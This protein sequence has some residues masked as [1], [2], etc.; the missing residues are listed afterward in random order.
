[1]NPVDL[2][3]GS[4]LFDPEWYADQ[5]G[6]SREPRRAARHYL[7]RG[8]KRGFTPHPLFD[9]RYFGRRIPTSTQSDPL[10]AFLTDPSLRSTP[11][12]PLFDS[13]AYLE[14][15]PDAAG[16]PW[17]PL[18]HYLEVGAAAGSRPNDWYQPHPEQEPGGIADWIRA[19]GREWSSRRRA[20]LPT[21]TTNYDVEAA[22]TVK[23]QFGEASPLAGHPGR[24]LV[25]V[26]VTSG[27]EYPTLTSTLRSVLEQTVPDVEILVADTGG[28]PN[29]S[30]AL[31]DSQT[32]GKVRVLGTNT[33]EVAALNRALSEGAGDYIAWVSPGERWEPDRLRLL[34]SACRAGGFDGVHDILRREDADGTNHFAGGAVTSAHLAVHVRGFLSQL[35]VERRVIGSVAPL[36]TTLPNGWE[37][38]FAYRA[39][40]TLR[41]GHVPV[42]G[43]HRDRPAHEQ[44]LRPP[45]AQRP[46]ADHRYV[47]TWNDVVVNR[48]AIDWASLEAAERDHSTVSVIIPTHRDWRRTLTA[49]R[50]V[51]ISDRPPGTHVEVIVYD[52]GSSLA[53]S[54]VLDSAAKRFSGVTVVHSPI[55][56]GFALGNNFALS[57]TRGEVVVFLN[58]DTSVARDWLGPLLEALREPEVLA[59]Q[60]LLVYPT[61]SVQSAG[62]AFPTC[63][64]IPHPYL[65]GFPVKDAAHVGSLSFGALTGAAL[66][67]RFDDVVK[68][69]GFDPLFRNGMED[70]DFCLRLGQHRD[71]RLVVAPS[72]AV[73]HHESRTPGR[74]A[75]SVANRRLYLDRWADKAPKDDEQL[76]ESAGFQVVGHEIRNQVADDRRLCVPEPVLTRRP[77]LDISELPPRL[78]W[79]IKNPATPGEWGEGWGDTHFARSLAKALDG[80]GQSVVI[81]NRPEFHRATGRLDDVV[82]VLRGLEPY[83]PSYGQVNLAWLISHPEILTRAEAESYDRLLAA[84]EH[85]AT[86]MSRAWDIRIDPLLQAT[87]PEVFHPDCAEPDTGH[88]VLFVGGSRD[89]FRPM[90]KDALQLGLPLAVY[91]RYWEQFIS[92]DHIKGTHVD[93]HRLG[94]MY[95]A[96]GVVLNDHWPMMRSEGFISNRL[97]DAAAAGARV[98]TDDV[99]GLAGLFGQ[100]VQVAGSAE[101]LARLADPSNFDIVFGDDDERRAVAARIRKEHS[102]DNRAKI[103]LETALEIRA[104]QDIRRRA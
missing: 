47:D 29:L 48:W 53:T 82:L 20:A 92:P 81:D 7:D 33:H 68:M 103:L 100:S 63:G 3:S 31:A 9:S 14:S 83:R 38:D 13:A 84:S 12:H 96:A 32:F 21:W 8:S 39:H 49:V 104:H 86:K 5:A 34:V 46:L 58:N 23:S 2:V 4:L 77:Q 98:I 79:A 10:V 54:A 75:H 102:F 11:T 50:S 35:L 19:R 51:C 15:E 61:G 6:C 72:S 16:H 37:L 28:I 24:P 67:V 99:Y 89:Q 59:A 101:D 80:L 74:F 27:Y 43:T 78:R 70:I 91:G 85:W 56:H 93:N 69:R 71:G 17:G 94:A 95:R 65:Q 55:N 18:G 76:W 26:I 66:A 64:G 97:F 44:A 40:R 36:D 62:V 87:D 22:E 42:V 1:M 45:A 52:N 88:P 41:L 30:A 25:S 90:V 60:S 57:H 73:T